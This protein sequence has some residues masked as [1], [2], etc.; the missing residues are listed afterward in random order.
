MS[1]RRI[2]SVQSSSLINIIVSRE[3]KRQNRTHKSP[4]LVHN[5]DKAKRFALFY[6]AKFLSEESCKNYLQEFG[7]LR[8]AVI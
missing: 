7:K 2:Y 1:H 4:N 8:K 5:Y 3:R 6:T